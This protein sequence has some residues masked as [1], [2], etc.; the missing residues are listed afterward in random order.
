MRWFGHD[1]GGMSE[2]TGA[3]LLALPVRLHGVQLGRPVDLLLDR[4]TLRTVGLDVLCGD[5]VHRFLPISAVTVHDDELAVSSALTMLDEPE[6][7]FYRTRASTL[8]ALR[9]SKLDGVFV[10]SDGTTDGLAAA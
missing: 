9:G 8:S 7:A 2:L 1:G 3:E 10:N 5:E 6:L 4:N